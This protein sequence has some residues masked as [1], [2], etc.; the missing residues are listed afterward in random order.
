MKEELIFSITVERV[1]EVAIEMI[2]RRLTESELT[3]VKR[4]IESCLLS[5]IHAV[6]ETA[7]SSVIET[8]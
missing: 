2:D 3:S 4:G 5:D 6:F 1:Q 7:I 8:K